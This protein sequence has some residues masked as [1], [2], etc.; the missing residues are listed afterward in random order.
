M[1]HQVERIE[2]I[3]L[4]LCARMKPITLARP[5]SMESTPPTA[6]WRVCVVL[7]PISDRTVAED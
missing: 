2:I 1:R 3:L 7:R 4:Q 6:E 5:N